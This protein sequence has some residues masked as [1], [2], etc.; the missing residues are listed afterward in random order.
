MTTPKR[1]PGRPPVAEDAR[2]SARVE[3]RLTQAQ[4]DKLERLGGA[5]WVRTRI[6]RA[7]DPANGG[8]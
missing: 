8:T 7:K 5:D 6:E 1:P 4:R 2:R 3:V